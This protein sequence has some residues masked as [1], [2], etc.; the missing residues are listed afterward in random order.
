MGIEKDH[1][2][3]SASSSKRWI[4]CP[5]SVR[6]CENIPEEPSEYAAEGT[7]AHSIAELKLQKEFVDKF[8]TVRTFNTRMNKL[9]KDP[10]YKEEMQGYTDIYE[11]HIKEI[12]YGLESVPYISVEK[13]LDYS[14]WAKEGFGTAD[15]IMIHGN[16]LY[17]NDLKYG[18]GVEVEAEGNSQMVLYALGAYEAYSF[19]YPIEKVTMTII[20][21]RLNKISE[22]T[23]PLEKLLAIGND[24]KKRA[25]LAW[26]GEGEF[27][28]GDHCKFCKALN[29]R[30][31][32]EK[33][34][35]LSKFGGKLPPLLTNEEVGEVLT[36]ATQLIAWHKKLQAY[37]MK[38][39]LSGNK[40]DGWKLVEGRSNRTFSDADKAFETL[41]S[42]GIPEEIL[43]EKQPLSLSKLEAQ[44]G[45]KQFADLVGD[46]IVKP[47]GSPTVVP[48]SD[49]REPYKRN[50]A[51]DDFK[52]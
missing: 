15:C 49:K 16:T 7:L 31:R 40:I 21:P 6:L 24:I 42:S 43:Y 47:K 51:A 22:W 29:C 37:A 52:E 25:E 18:V 2:L 44:L 8:M 33:N 4:E 9:K 30:A 23:I 32:A 39:L 19:L 26:N 20:Q 38:E 3:L 14:R 35:E 34:L 17:V 48:E 5:P 41:K 50:S 10:L 46:F 13:K 28:A 27:K 12:A 1:A 45:K 36:K 11:E